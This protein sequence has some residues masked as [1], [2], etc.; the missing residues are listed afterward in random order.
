MH[1]RIVSLEY[2]KADLRSDINTLNIENSKLKADRSIKDVFLKHQSSFDVLGTVG[3]NVL[4]NVIMAYATTNQVEGGVK[5]LTH[6][7][8][9]VVEPPNSRD[10]MNFNIACLYALANDLYKMIPYLVNALEREYTK[11]DF[12]KEADFKAFYT[13]ELFLFII[14][15]PH[16]DTIVLENY[17]EHT[18]TNTFEKVKLI[19]YCGTDMGD[20]L[21]VYK[22][23]HEITYESGTIG[24]EGVVQQ[25]LYESKTA[26][27]TTYF[28]L[29]KQGKEGSEDPSQI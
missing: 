15:L 10:V 11:E 7:F 20:S 25:E 6:Y 3:Y 2:E 21:Y 13:D 4:T 1:S 23:P 22:E 28:K 12:L 16:K 18:A 17:Q 24:E 8:D 14:G 19:A 27:L 5:A 29:S 26:P 9:L